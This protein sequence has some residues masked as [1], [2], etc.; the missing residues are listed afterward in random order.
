VRAGCCL[1]V[2]SAVHLLTS[3]PHSPQHAAI[4]REAAQQAVVVVQNPSAG[5]DGAPL[6]PLSMITK[7]K[8]ALIG[9]MGNVTDVFLGDY[10]PAACPGKAKPA[11]EG[12]SCLP[13]LLELM[14]KQA[15]VGTVAFAPGC[16]QAAKGPKCINISSAAMQAATAA[17]AGADVVILTIGEK[18]TDNDND[19]H[20]TGGEGSDRSSI[21]LPGQQ[22][23]A[24]RL[25]ASCVVCCPL[26]RATPTA[27]HT[28]AH[29]DTC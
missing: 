19:G 2:L 24:D 14:Q 3:I 13:T 1:H 17:M 4:A 27:P 5:A 9:P 7:A 6:L 28:A 25:V 20:N 12:T 16:T 11:P 8:Y 21:G 18:T 15:G 10:R 29:T 22:V 23:S 26:R